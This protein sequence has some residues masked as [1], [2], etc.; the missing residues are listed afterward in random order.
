MQPIGVGA[1]KSPAP[2]IVKLQPIGVGAKKSP[3]PAIVKFYV[4]QEPGSGGKE[5]AENSVRMLAGWRVALLD[6]LFF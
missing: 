2:A 4:E 5:S 6:S 3:A 1:K